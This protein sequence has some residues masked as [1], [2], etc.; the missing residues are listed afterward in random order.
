MECVLEPEMFGAL[1]ARVKDTLNAQSL[2][3]NAVMRHLMEK[4]DK[5]ELKIKKN[6][7]VV[8]T[9]K[10]K[11]ISSF[12]PKHNGVRIHRTC[13]NV[14]EK[15]N[16]SDGRNGWEIVYIDYGGL[17]TMG[18]ILYGIGIV[19]AIVPGIVVLNNKM[20][21]IFYLKKT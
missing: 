5:N 17:S 16:N 15:F 7:M 9:M 14:K 2:A 11:K 12:Y 10:Y 18:S 21:V 1:D 20:K 8:I 3:T 6:G 19:A 13:K 4:I